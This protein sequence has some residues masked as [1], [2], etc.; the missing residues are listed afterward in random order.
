MDDLMQ[1]A[2]A[3]LQAG[4]PAEADALCRCVLE[5]APLHPDA[6]KLRV[7]I[8]HREGR[9]HDALVILDDAARVE[10]AN[11]VWRIGR[12][13]V[14]ASLHQT[15]D[16][17]AAYD[18]AI[19]LSPED[20]EFHRGRAFALLAGNRLEEA[21]AGF[22]AALALR[23]DAADWHV[24][25]G[26]TLQR[27][28]RHD[29]ALAA[30][31]KAIEIQ[32]D[33]ANA[34]YSKA[35]LLLSLAR[36][37]EGWALHEWRW[38]TP[39][40]PDPERLFPQPFWDGSPLEGRTLLVHAEQGLGDSI[41]FYRFVLQ[42][43]RQGPVAAMIPAKLIRLFASQP[44][45]PPITSESDKLPRFDVHCPMGSLPFLLGCS[46]ETIPAAP[47]LT[48][49]PKLIESW[50]PR[51]PAGKFRVGIVW[52][53][54]S[55]QANDRNRSM[56]LRTMLDMLDPAATIISLQKDVPARDRETLRRAAHVTDLGGDLTDF[57]DTAA[58]IAQLDLVITVC[59][60]VSHLAGAM[61]APVWVV[62]S[63]SADW[64][65]LLN[66]EDSPWYPSARLFRQEKPDD[67]SGVARRALRERIGPP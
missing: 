36:Y 6:L 22:D 24:A 3:A 31:D 50:R 30:Y 59:T 18:E 9:F 15:A 37:P 21:L 38:F 60:S 11:V 52:A 25:R 27:L 57:A 39:N 40:F 42:A 47:Y 56:P 51:L 5:R 10:P 26:E 44:G 2:I 23:P 65:W 14:L 12:A 20:P 32:D 41:Q 46:I 29:D 49:D 53:G 8:A 66:R 62:L 48:A 55:A 34:W 33:C 16:A 64:R 35:L 19:A 63:A 28:H 67:W 7:D 13:R 4:A 58:V 61:G 45:A 43:R 17:I 54:N 1:Q